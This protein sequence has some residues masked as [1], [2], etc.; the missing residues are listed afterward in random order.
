MV[1]DLSTTRGQFIIIVLQQEPI[2]RGEEEA[3]GYRV[4]A[5]ARR[6]FLRHVHRQ[7]LGEVGYGCLGRG[8]GRDVGKRPD[9]VHRGDIQNRSSFLLSHYLCHSLTGKECSHEVKVEG[10][11]DCLF[12][13]IEEGDFCAGRRFRTISSGTVYKEVDTSE[14]LN[15]VSCRIV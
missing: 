10:E 1:D 6:I 14:C 15:R 2:L 7:P 5:D 13:Q 4:Y 8:V 3:G 12:R 11:P 9:R